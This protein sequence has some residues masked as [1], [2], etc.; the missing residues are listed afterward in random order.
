MTLLLFVCGCLR[1]ALPTAFVVLALTNKGLA[2]ALLLPFAGLVLAVAVYDHRDRERR[3][4]R[5]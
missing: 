3:R 1:V 2:N 4:A 5:R